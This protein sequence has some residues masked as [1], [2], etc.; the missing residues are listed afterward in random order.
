MNVP[1]IHPKLYLGDLEDS[2]RWRRGGVGATVCVAGRHTIEE[3]RPTYAVLLD[4]R[5][6]VDPVN[7][8]RAMQLAAFYIREALMLHPRVLVHCYAG[9]NRSVSA[10]VAYTKLYGPKRCIVR[11]VGCLR[12]PQDTMDYL[13]TMNARNRGVHTLTNSTF[14]SLLQD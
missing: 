10:L 7:F 12:R 8:D 5:L 9:V 2:K 11:A 3:A 1:L 13:T 6:D 4:D 14:A